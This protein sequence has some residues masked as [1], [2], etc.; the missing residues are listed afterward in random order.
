MN[1]LVNYLFVLIT[2]IS[3][4]NFTFGVNLRHWLGWL[5]VFVGFI[6]GVFVAW[7]QGVG[8]QTITGVFFLFLTIWLGHIRWRQRKG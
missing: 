8:S 3:V 7:G 5:Q 4:Y 2:L 6:T 1:T